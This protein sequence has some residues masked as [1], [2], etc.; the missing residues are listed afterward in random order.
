MKRRNFLFAAVAG[1]S[2]I[3]FID[4]WSFVSGGKTVKNAK[5]IP[6]FTQE[7]ISKKALRF[8]IIGDWGAGGIFQK[9]VAEAMVTQAQKHKPSY[10]ISTGDNIYPDGVESADDTQWK[11]KFEMMY[12]HESIAVPWYAVLGNHDYRNNPDAQIEYHA[13]NPRW[14]MPARYYT[15]SAASNIDCFMLDTQMIMQKKANE[16]ILWFEKA[17]S[18]SKAL[19]KIVV[20]HHPMRSYGHY[21]DSHNLV[22]DIKPIMEKYGAQLYLCGHDHDIQW[23]KNPSDTFTCLVSGAGGGARD[24]AYGDH[25]VFAA[26]NGGFI[27]MDIENMTAYISCINARGEVVFYQKITA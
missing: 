25:T 13:K 17:M 20:G 14:N 6:P 12:N 19:W 8:F 7:N 24:T 22:R 15:W 2:S 26:T 11:T 3:S 27:S 1:L 10:I 5:P 9:R 23:I 4:L 16:Q 18:Q 21:G